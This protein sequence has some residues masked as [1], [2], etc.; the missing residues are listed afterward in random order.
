[1]RLYSAKQMQLADEDAISR[2]GI[3]GI[4]LMENAALKSIEKMQ[5]LFG[6]IDDLRFSIVCGKGNNGGDGIAIARH[7]FSR[8]ITFNL[9]I[10]GVPKTQDALLNW[11]IINNLGIQVT[12]VDNEAAMQ[13][14]Q[15]A[16]QLSDVIIDCIII[17]I[18]RHTNASISC[19]YY[20]IFNYS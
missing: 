5:S 8:N 20:V 4:V 2:V 15:I 14:M 3:P 1:M 18:S 17:A 11:R 19:L 6:S 10:T 9:F 13:K 7:L 12:V 16:L